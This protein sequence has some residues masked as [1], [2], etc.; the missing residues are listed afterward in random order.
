MAFAL[1]CFHFGMKKIYPTVMLGSDYIRELRKILESIPNVSNIEIIASDDFENL[2]IDSLT[3]ITDGG[4]FFPP[5]SFDLEIHFDIYIPERLQNELWKGASDDLSTEKFQIHIMDSYNFPVTIIEL[6]DANSNCKPSIAVI[7]IREFLKQQFE[8]KKFEYI[9]FSFL[10]PSPFHADFFLHENNKHKSDIDFDLNGF[11]I[12]YTPQPG[13]DTFTIFYTNSLYP[14]IKEAKEALFLELSDD[15][16]SFYSIIQCNLLQI[17]EW[18]KLEDLINILIEKSKLTR[19]KAIW[20]KA[21]YLYG[22]VQEIVIALSEFESS[23]IWSSFYIKKD[24]QQLLNIGKKPYLDKFLQE[25]MSEFPDY[26]VEQIKGIIDLLENRR[27]KTIDNFIIVVAALIGGII[28]A[29]ITI[30]VTP[31]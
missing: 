1:G 7:V 11:S 17:N 23:R 12:D 22:Q 26:P 9:R 31:H 20:Y 16:G 30:L 29:L 13:Y 18:E 4:S 10:G 15:A 27:S 28:G 19:L 6:I 2:K 3:S 25:A 14:N 24:Y 8:E 5:A 21:F